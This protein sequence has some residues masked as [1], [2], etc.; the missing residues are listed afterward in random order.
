M[1]LLLAGIGACSGKAISALAWPL[2]MMAD[3]QIAS[4]CLVS[5]DCSLL[6]V[7]TGRPLT[8]MEPFFWV[9]TLISF[10]AGGWLPSRVLTSPETVSVIG[11]SWVFESPLGLKPPL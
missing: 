8:L 3:L 2:P 9:W 7:Q 6:A 11:V 10:S 5:C 4:A 1:I